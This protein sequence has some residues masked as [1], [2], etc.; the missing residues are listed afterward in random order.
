MLVDDANDIY[1][2][3]YDQS[4]H[5]PLK[6]YIINNQGMYLNIPKL[7][8]QIKNDNSDAE[9]IDHDKEIKDIC[10][11]F[12]TNEFFKTD[13]TLFNFL[14]IIALQFNNALDIYK[15]NNLL[16]GDSIIFTFKGGNIL[17]IIQREFLNEIPGAA[18][19]I[20]D[21]YYSK[22][23]QRSDA[24]FSIYINPNLANLERV[25]DDVTSLSYANQLVLQNKFNEN[26][27]EY[28]DFFKLNYF[29]KTKTLANYA[30]KIANA[31]CFTD[32]KNPKYYQS[33]FAQLLINDIAAPT[34][35]IGPY[36]YMGIPNKLISPQNPNNTSIINIQTVSLPNTV[37]VSDNRAL[38]FQNDDLLTHFNLTRSKVALNVVLIK[39]NL[40]YN[41][42]VSGELIDVSISRDGQNTAFFSDL[43]D[44]VSEYNLHTP[45]EKLIFKSYSYSFLI[46]D[47]ELILI[48]GNKLPWTQG[49][50]QKRLSR[51][52]LLYFIDLSI[53]D[54]K[55][56]NIT[57]VQKLSYLNMIL[58][59]V[60]MLLYQNQE[61]S[62]SR[63]DKI[64]NIFPDIFFA[65]FIKKLKKLK[66]GSGTIEFKKFITICIENIAQLIDTVNAIED[67]ENKYKTNIPEDRL[68]TG[69]INY[70]LV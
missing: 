21:S 25:I 19:E 45:N 13:T 52:F 49:K 38:K 56:I 53:Y 29:E 22:D 12:V 5:A 60:L 16:P 34:L 23:F 18:M 27:A 62:D 54:P 14:K 33:N 68:Y 31:K 47:L 7:Q 26:P 40:I 9:Y 69:P 50:Y 30:N 11:S 46:H 20:L 59:D 65:N 17:K 8:Q 6:N 39:N 48:H 2:D 64:A 3:R 10:T 43:K 4:S 57:N 35:N 24:D 70:S 15:K 67:Y 55:D 63:F 36:P 32:P 1:S 51:L 41:V 58:D 28:F 66:N 44:N 37:F 42:P 61:V